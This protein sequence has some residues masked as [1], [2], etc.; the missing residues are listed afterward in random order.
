MK[1]IHISIDDTINVFQDLTTYGENYSSI[2]DNWFLKELKKLHDDYG[3]KFTLYCFL[4]N[5]DLSFELK[6]C[7][8][9]FRQEFKKNK[10]WLRFGFHGLNGKTKLEKLTA[11]EIESMYLDFSNILYKVTGLKPY[12]LVRIHNWN[13]N[14]DTI[15]M[16]KKYRLKYLTREDNDKSYNLSDVDLEKLNLYGKVISNGITYKKSSFRLEKISTHDMEDILNCKTKE[17]YI[18][19]HEWMLYDNLN[20]TLNKLKLIGKWASKYI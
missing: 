1:K 12:K 4:E 2:F 17:Y 7:T 19:T 18:Y 6:N 11:K 20:E 3:M 13:L 8:T 15:M 16:L 14:Y 9:K 5:M 10:K